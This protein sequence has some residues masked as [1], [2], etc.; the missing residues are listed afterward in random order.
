[1]LNKVTRYILVGNPRVT[2]YDID[3]YGNN[4]IPVINNEGV[5]SYATQMTT[6][7]TI[8]WSKMQ[9]LSN[10]QEKNAKLIEDAK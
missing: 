9:P 6:N 8:D 7:T 4:D 10:N 2:R 1:M 3:W 5:Q